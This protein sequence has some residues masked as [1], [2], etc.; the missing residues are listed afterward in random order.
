MPSQPVLKPPDPYA[1]L[2]E[3]EALFAQQLDRMALS[4]TSLFGRRKPRLTKTLKR[5][6]RR[7]MHRFLE[8]AKPYLLGL[9]ALDGS[10]DRER[11]QYALL[12][13]LLQLQ[14]RAARLRVGSG[15]DA[16]EAQ[17]RLAARAAKPP[18][19]SWTRHPCYLQTRA[20]LW[21]FLVSMYARMNPRDI[22]GLFDRWVETNDAKRHVHVTRQLLTVLRRFRPE[23]PLK[24]TD[25]LITDLS[26]GYRICSAVFEQRL[27]LFLWWGTAG[28][29][30]TQPW[31]HWKKQDLK[32]LLEI[33]AKD[34]MLNSLVF[35]INRN[36]RNAL[37][38]GGPE[39]DVNT[40]NCEF[41]DRDKVVT[42]TFREFYERTLCLALVILAMLQFEPLFQLAQS[43]ALAFAL[44]SR[45]PQKGSL[46]SDATPA[47]AP[48]TSHP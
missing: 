28:M 31:S 13:G 37:A 44:W 23:P 1:D 15:E 5:D 18:R 11:A 17:I 33:G 34:P 19:S 43:R 27:R 4:I 9:G 29:G 36:V 25:R 7:R 45:F 10:L 48:C 42:W 24:L 41:P 3:I 6:F 22:Q 38:H 12:E 35:A 46:S 40:G 21:S 26:E 16:F 20:T 8:Q 2:S 32:G 47:V 39:V 14:M 30:A